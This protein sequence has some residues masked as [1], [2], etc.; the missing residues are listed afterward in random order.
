MSSVQEC[1]SAEDVPLTGSL[2][3]QCDNKRERKWIQVT[4]EVFK[5]ERERER[6]Q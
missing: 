5:P 1:Y 3:E 6:E 2:V 4:S